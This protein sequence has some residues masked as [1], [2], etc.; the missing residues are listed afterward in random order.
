M[1]KFFENIKLAIRAIWGKKIR[2]FLTMLGVIIGVFAIVLLIG[3][4]EG[5]KSEVTGQIEGLGSNLVFLTP[6]AGGPGG[7]QGVQAS[8]GIAF[9]PEDVATIEKIVGVKYVVPVAMV[10]LPISNSK[11]VV[12]SAMTAEQIQASAG[13]SSESESMFYQSSLMAMATTTNAEYAFTGNVFS[14]AEYGRMFTEE[15][16]D[17]GYKVAVVLSG[18]LKQ[19]YPNVSASEVVGGSIY[20]GKEEFEIVGTVESEDEE[21][22][23]IF[24]GQGQGLS[25][26]VIIPLTTAHEM[27][28]SD[29]VDQ[30]AVTVEDADKVDVVKEE[31][32]IALLETHEGVEDFSMLTQDEL[33]GMFDQILGVLTTMLGGI[34][35]IS[36]LVGGIGVMNIMLV[37]VTERTKEI[38]LRKAIG[39]SGIDIMIQFLVE[40][41]F[42]TFLG[43]TTGIGLAFVGSII[44]DTQFGFAPVLTIQSILIAFGFCVVIGIFFGVAPAIRAARLDP[45]DAL[46]YE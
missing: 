8:G 6:G 34:A 18:A 23:G 16:Y 24:G 25:D 13:T 5:V 17:S 10:P 11:P 27:T 37:S 36:L 9:A 43:G 22:S 44:M 39:A 31:I 40:A 30:I 33:L 46:K 15:E 28:D 1:Y 4:G 32:R 26:I 3:I 12:P 41:V 29:N 20:I 19:L 2:S 38:G 21:E 42:L 45:I 14:G 35:A 7:G